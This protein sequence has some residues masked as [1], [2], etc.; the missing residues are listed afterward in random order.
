MSTGSLRAALEQAPPTREQIA[1]YRADDARMASTAVAAAGLLQ[2]PTQARY[3]VVLDERSAAVG[4]T[5]EER[6][7]YLIE[8][9]RRGGRWLVTAFTVTP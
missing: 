6:I 4:P 2:T 8:L 5:V 9:Q 7:A 3:R 1:G